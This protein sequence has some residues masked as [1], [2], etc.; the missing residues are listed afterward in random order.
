MSLDVALDLRQ[1]AR[2]VQLPEFS[3][4]IKKF[5]TLNNIFH[6]GR[7]KRKLQTHCKV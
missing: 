2:L 4:R 1:A 7:S 3:R 6:T 5:T